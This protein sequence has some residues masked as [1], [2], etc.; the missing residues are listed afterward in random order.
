MSEELETLKTELEQTKL[1]YQMAAQIGLF[2]SGFLA[3][4][5]HELR[6]PLNSLLG[7]HQLILADLCESPEE[8]RE[9]VKQAHE[10]AL[11]LIKLLDDIIYVSKVEYGFTRVE[12][13]PF[14][15]TEVFGELQRL[16]H[17]QAANRSYELEI[18][19]PEPEL[20]IN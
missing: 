19:Y 14:P 20:Y 8:E 18:D 15:L 16:I 6:S 17:L 7:L 4:T 5:S 13:H 1:A 10:A 9:F 2:K 3:R 12:I 11:K